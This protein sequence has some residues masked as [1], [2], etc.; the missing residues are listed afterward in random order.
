LECPIT[1]P[2]TIETTYG[3]WLNMTNMNL[4]ATGVD[5]VIH[6]ALNINKTISIHDY[7]ARYNYN[8]NTWGASAALNVYGTF[9]PESDYFTA[10]T[11]MNGSTIDLSAT[12][13]V[14]VCAAEGVR[15]RGGQY[16]LTSGGAFTG[17]N[18]S[19]VDKPNWVKGV[20]VVNGDIVLDVKFRGVFIFVK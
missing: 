11:M 8:A 13:N 7:R 14:K 18:V 3:G 20:S 10:A 1:G 4:T 16:T 6:S 17:A 15:P 5:F 12:V 2:G 9:T 19:L